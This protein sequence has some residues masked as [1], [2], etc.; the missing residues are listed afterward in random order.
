MIFDNCII[1][2]PDGVKLSRCCAKKANWYLTNNLASKISD[3]PLTVRLNFEPSGRLG[4]TDPL[5][6]EGKPNHCVV[7]GITENLTRHHIVPYSFVKHVKFATRSDVICDI[8][9]LCRPCH[10]RYEDKSYEKRLELAQRFDCPIYGLNQNEL[11]RIRHATSAAHTLLRHRENLPP[12]R[13]EFLESLVKEFISKDELTV[14]DLKA[15]S[16]A[17][18]NNQPNYKNFAKLVTDSMSYDEFAKE[19]RI[20]F[21]ETMSPQF[22]PKGWEVNR[23]SIPVSDQQPCDN[24]Q[25]PT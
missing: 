17:R 1:E 23:K 10:D 6:E 22:M 21:L 9:P 15:T 11:V 24:C 19:W 25:P 14:E 8:M 4:L 12:E 2:A 16:K 20:H 3:N 13:A 5:L 7:C 18:I